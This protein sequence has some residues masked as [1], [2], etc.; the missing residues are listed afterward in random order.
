MR[1]PIFHLLVLLGAILAAPAD[2]NRVLIETG[3][4]GAPFTYNITSSNT[5]A[6]RATVAAN[7]RNV[8]VQFMGDSTMRGVNEAASPYN[9]QYPS[10]MPMQLAALFNA[11]GR[12][13]GANNWFGLSGTSLNDYVIRDSRIAVGGSAAFGNLI[14]QGGTNVSF[15]SSGSSTFSFTSQFNVNTGEIYY[16]DFSSG[17][18]FSYQVDGGTAV[19]VVQTGSN[20]IKKVT[21]SLGSLGI[22]TILTSW[23]SGN[24]VDIYGIN[25]YDATRVEMSIWQYGISGGTSADMINDSGTTHAG[26][27][28]QMA[29]FP[30]DL[31]ICECGLVNS[32]RNSESVASSKSDLTTLVQAAKAAGANFLFLVPPWDNGSTGLTANQSAYVQAMYQVAFEQ[33]VGL[34]DL[35]KWWISYNYS[36]QQ[37]WQLN[38]DAV[39]PSLW[40]Y[41]SEATLIYTVINAIIANKF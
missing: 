24:F 3:Y 26:R 20:T 5:S 39:H 31:V 15:A 9:S 40:G 29:D 23:V 17:S 37:G 10:A 8:I 35:R 36:V 11:G 21:F 13:A 1:R 6:F 34:I 12:A 22:H 30:P 18:T 4:S 33:N 19:N 38:S 25:T 28:T 27:L 32:W 16:L 2:A 7:S 14:I 41:Q